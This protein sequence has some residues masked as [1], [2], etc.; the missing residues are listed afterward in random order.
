MKPKY[1]EGDVIVHKASREIAVV[2]HVIS[3]EEHEHCVC[4]DCRDGILTTHY[5]LS[6]GYALTEKIRTDVVDTL[7]TLEK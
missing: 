5:V 4:N 2:L 7:T 3:S 1:K 6:Y